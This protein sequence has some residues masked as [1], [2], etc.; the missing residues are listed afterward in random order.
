[1]NAVVSTRSAC[2]LSAQAAAARAVQARINQVFLINK[3]MSHAPGAVF[4]CGATLTALLQAQQATPT[5]HPTDDVLAAIHSKVD[6]IDAAV[7]AAR[8]KGV[9]E[10][11]IADVDV[12]A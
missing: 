2:G 7:K 6:K 12:Y 10:D 1:M 4:L 3:S 8:A 11:L 5:I 9:N